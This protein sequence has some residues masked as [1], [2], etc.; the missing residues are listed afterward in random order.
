MSTRVR[1]AVV[2]TGSSTG[3]GRATALALDRQGFE[4][5]AGVRRPE[6]GEALRASASGS[7]EPLIVDVTDGASIAAAAARVREATG[8]RLAGLVNN[9]GVVVPG[10]VEGIELD[11]L[12]RQLEVNVVGQVAVTQ[13]FLSMIRAARGRV[14]FMSSIGGRMSVPHLSPY[15]ASKHA[16][17][18]IG[19]SLRQ[20]MRRFGVG[21]AIIEPGAVATPFWDKGLGEAPKARAAMGADLLAIY[22]D[23]LDRIEAASE[24]TAARGVP[25]ERVADAVVHAL[26][27]AKPRTRYLVGTDAK[28]QAAMRTVLPARVFDRL[29]A[30]ELGT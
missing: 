30:R 10:P 8:A 21:V 4:V 18:A 13:A 15:H 28:L 27:D 11:E 26:T 24:R 19:D 3:I 22:G 6:D 5:F 23:E 1:G 16:L 20:E 25:P 9:A 2:I 7:L 14:V 12:R 29:I 17:E